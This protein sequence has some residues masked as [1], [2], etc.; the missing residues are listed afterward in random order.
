MDSLRVG[1]YLLACRNRRRI[2][3]DNNERTHDMAIL[4]SGGCGKVLLPHNQLSERP[5][6]TYY[7][8]IKSLLLHPYHQKKQ[9]TRIGGLDN[10]TLFELP[11]TE[12]ANPRGG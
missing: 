10:I 2:A 9:K 7:Y 5:K 3:R 11:E 1:G 12:Q 6:P 4:M 8:Y